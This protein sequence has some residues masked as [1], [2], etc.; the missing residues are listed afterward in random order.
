MYEAP[1]LDRFGTFRELTLQAPPGVICTPPRNFKIYTAT[2]YIAVV[3][4]DDG[5]LDTR[6]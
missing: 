5:C 6:S 3:G 1:R 4:Q 2:D